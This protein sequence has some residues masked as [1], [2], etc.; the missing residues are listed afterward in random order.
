LTKSTVRKMT[1][2]QRDLIDS[3]NEFC[4]EKFDYTKE[5]TLEEASEYISRNIEQ[6]KLFTM[7]EW[8]A[9]YS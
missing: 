2:K 4:I 1:D 8:H 7:D 3:M 6:F 9:K 5:T